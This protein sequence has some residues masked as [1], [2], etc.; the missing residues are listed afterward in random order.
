MIELFTIFGKGGLVYWCL[1][2]GG[3]LFTESINKLIRDVLMQERGDVNQFKHNNMTIKFHM[4]NE[5]ELVFMVVYQSIIQLSYADKLLTEVNKRFRDL[6]KNVLDNKQMMYLH[7]MNSF[8]HFTEEFEGIHNQCMRQSLNE[9]EVV[10]KPKTFQESHKSQ[11]TVESL[12]VS[13]PG[14]DKNKKNEA[15]K[16]Q[17][18]ASE[19]PIEVP[20]GSP[21]SPIMG[22]GASSDEEDDTKRK[23]EEFM[24]KM[25]GGA[26]KAKEAP[27]S[28]EA[29]KK[30]GKEARVWN[31]S[32]K[33]KDV[34]V[35]DYSSGKA[36]DAEGNGEG[37]EDLKFVEEQR[38]FVG[39]S[40]KLE[41]LQESDDEEEDDAVVEERAS[42]GGWFSSLKNLVG[43]KK[44]TPEDVE[45]LMEKMRENLILKNVAAE[46]AEKICQSVAKKLEGKVI[47]TF[48][49]INSEVKE[50]I[51]E[52]LTQ[53]LT[54]KRRVDILRDVI[55]AKKEKRP[56]VVVFCGVNGVGKST[57]LAK[58]TFWLNE[59]GHRVLIAAGDTFRAGA[60]EQLRTHTR[61]LNA[62]HPD[63]VQL[64]EQGYGKDP[65]GLAAAAIAIAQERGHDVVLVDTSGRMQDNE[66]LMRALAKL[67][68]VN[69]PDLCLFVGEALVGNE[70]VDQLV[71]FNQALADH[72]SPG[73]EPRLID[74]IVLTKFDTIDDKVGAAISMT[75][76]TGQPIV[77]VGCGQTYRDLRTLNAAAVVTALLK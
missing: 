21:P 18:K 26:S 70:A 77:F 73:A 44:I 6:Y 19:K 60:V 55:E 43:S 30:K 38:Q 31:L 22:S 16:K 27:A 72:A 36:E 51:R 47:G 24:R 53:L 45:P 39:R 7:G 17:T 3:Q 48:T 63:S 75:Y 69:E 10:R 23:R 40:A 59:N 15:A 13:R 25:K 20:K 12:I 76:I 58:I 1:Q 8:M 56:Y 66:P 14:D 9:A 41:D 5:F 50:A 62:L 57:N 68:R 37:V 52:S 74:G 71:K 54:P 32:G 35:L 11:K 4:D 29:Q 42:S 2:E 61:H 49:R 65:A 34:P 67:I 64:Y 28:P 33:T 46:P